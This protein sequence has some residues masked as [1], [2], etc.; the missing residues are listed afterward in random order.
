MF[1]ADVKAADEGDFAIDQGD[2]AVIA[3]REGMN[4]PDRRKRSNVDPC[5][6]R[7]R[8]GSVDPLGV[9][10]AERIYAKLY[11]AFW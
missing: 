9:K 3:V 4:V 11:L 2:L 8:R 6:S 10:K 1:I 5:L 7:L